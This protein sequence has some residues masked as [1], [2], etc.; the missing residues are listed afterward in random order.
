MLWILSK[1]FMEL[2]VLRISILFF[3]SFEVTPFLLVVI[4]WSIVKQW[5]FQKRTSDQH[6]VFW[7]FYNVS[8]QLLLVF[9]I[10]FSIILSITFF[11]Y[12]NPF[13][14]FN[15]QLLFSVLF[16]KWI[17]L[18]DVLY[19]NSVSVSLAQFLKFLFAKTVMAVFKEFD[20][21]SLC[22]RCFPIFANELLLLN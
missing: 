13:P 5:L 6:I 10:C 1:L 9:N 19:K 22:T 17:C 2:N 8:I 21:Y 18:Y 15:F 20:L 4:R 11:F 12:F 14:G 16:L 3:S 7:S